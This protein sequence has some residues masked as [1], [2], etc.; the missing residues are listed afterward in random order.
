MRCVV[1][2]QLVQGRKRKDARV[3]A[4]ECARQLAIH[5]TKAWKQKRPFSV[6]AGVTPGVKE[7]EEAV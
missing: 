3:C 4:G 6:K 2:N 5:R 1:C 7:L